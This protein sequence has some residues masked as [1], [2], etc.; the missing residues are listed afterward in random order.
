LVLTACVSSGIAAIVFF[1]GRVCVSVGPFEFSCSEADRPFLIFLAALF[2]IVLTWRYPRRREKISDR[3]IFYGLGLAGATWFI[4]YSTLGIYLHWT[5]RSN[6]LDMA[7]HSQ[8]LWNLTQGN[9]MVSSFFDHSFAANH[10]WPGL[11][12]MLPFYLLGGNEGMIVLQAAA[13]S[14][15]VFPAYLLAREMTG[16]RRWGVCLALCLLIHPTFGSGA[17]FDYHVELLVVPLIMMSLLNLRRRRFTATVILTGLSIAIYEV[18]A[19]PYAFLGLCMLPWRRW[20][21]PGLLLFGSCVAYLSLIMGVVMP[22]FSNPGYWS[23]A[24]RFKKLGLTPIEAFTHFFQAPI[25][26]LSRNTSPTRISTLIRLLGSFAFLPLAGFELLLPVI[27]LMLIYYMSS[28]PVQFDIRYGYLA[29]TLPFFF[30]AAVRGAA[31]LCRIPGF[32]GAM[33]QRFGGIILLII[34]FWFSWDVQVRGSI[35]RHEFIPRPNHRA[36]CEASQLIPARV[37]LATTGHL[38]PHFARREVL[39]LAPDYYH[40]GSPVDVVFLDLEDTAAGGELL[41]ELRMILEKKE[42]TPKWFSQGVLVLERDGEEENA[43][44]VSR[45]IYYIDLKTKHGKSP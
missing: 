45:I 15:V 31:R 22:Y 43:D 10:F 23:Q 30:L 39:K 27:P 5:W 14:L 17:L 24:A 3:E 41:G 9:F 20:R 7:L 44:L 32:I 28:F 40:N 4:F 38:G 2:A 25:L 16:S 18:S 34:S 6:S 29:V 13:I 19:M 8:L 35:R 33:L 11:Y 26:F 36:I 21:L 1:S 37:S 12:L 42:W